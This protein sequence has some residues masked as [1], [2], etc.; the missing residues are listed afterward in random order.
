MSL[1]NKVAI[2]TVAIAELVSHR[3]E[4]LASVAGVVIDYVCTDPTRMMR[5]PSR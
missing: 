2:V 4:L 3:F 1:Q 5:L